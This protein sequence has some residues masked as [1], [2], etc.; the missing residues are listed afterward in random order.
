[1]AK[2]DNSRG[3]FP[4]NYSLGWKFI[5]ESKRFIYIIASIF[6][7]FAIIG[8][9]LPVPD[10][11]AQELMKILGDIA[12]RTEGLSWLE[13]TGFILSNNVQASF[14]GMIFG[15][16]LGIFPVI[17]AAFNGYILGFVA[18]MA[19]NESGLGTLLKLLPHGIFELPAVFISLGIGLR[20][21]MLIIHSAKAK[22]LR[23][24]IKELA[25]VFF[26]VIAPLLIIAALIEASLIILSR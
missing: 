20:M 21:G 17:F 4:R 18:L 2:R 14:L 5:K 25:R 24:Y 7:A 3:F 15:V 23:Y 22:S 9:F 12:K 13:L 26:L 19:S 6:F 16:F 10:Y 8:F 11:I 1:M